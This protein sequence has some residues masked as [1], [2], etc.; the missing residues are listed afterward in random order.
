MFLLKKFNKR[1]LIQKFYSVE[2]Y[3]KFVNSNE[4]H[5]TSPQE[6]FQKTSQ[7]FTDENVNNSTLKKSILKSLYK[8]AENKNIQALKVL[9]F[10]F[11][12]GEYFE[13]LNL[14]TSF[15]YY[16]EAAE[17][18]D[19]ES[20]Y[21]VGMMYIR[22]YD[23]ANSTQS[24][25]QELLTNEQISEIDEETNAFVYLDKKTKSK[26][27]Y[28]SKEPNED[29]KPEG[30]SE[31]TTKKKFMQNKRKG[32]NW[33]IKA[34]ENGN[35]KAMVVLSTYY[36]EGGGGLE[37]N[38]FKARELLEKASSENVDAIYNLGMIYYIGLKGKIDGK[39]VEIEQNTTKAMEYFH[40]AAY[41]GDA[42]AQYWLGHLYHQG[43]ILER[44]AE[45]SLVYL[46]SAMQQNHPGSIFYLALMYKNGDGVEQDTRMFEEYF[47]KSVELNHADA[48]YLLGDFY[49]HGKEGRKQN[50]QQAFE[51][52]RQAGE[53]GNADA[54]Y[55]LGVM[56]FTGKGTKQNQKKAAEAY[57]QAG[58]LG[59]KGALMALADMYM[60]GIGVERDEKQAQ[61]L[62]KILEKN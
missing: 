30:V 24:N 15:H 10:A 4:F 23:F 12:T 14:E 53:L 13:L 58:T 11:S 31:S 9:G 35:S 48:L 17:L 45:K 49:F 26:R 38:I 7:V 8:C 36:I 42:S 37:A 43:N 27:E 56:L 44:D 40:E 39:S 1:S 47:Q 21:I 19:S 25:I 62:L 51:Y 34:S 50:Y 18:N 60:K 33:L 6:I 54:L 57:T 20:Q 55:C 59:S 29:L 2:N 3:I 22:G 16:L 41:K 52:F 61:N 5:Q 32:I 28:E 46:N